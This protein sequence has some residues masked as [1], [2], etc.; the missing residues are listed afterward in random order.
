MVIKTFLV[1]V[2]SRLNTEED[3]EATVALPN[4]PPPLPPVS[5]SMKPSSVE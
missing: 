5:S 4:H 2:R 3:V 1:S